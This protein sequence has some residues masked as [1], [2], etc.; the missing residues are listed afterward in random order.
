MT[1]VSLINLG[2]AKNE[3]DSEEMLGVLAREGYAIES[4]RD[5]TAISGRAI[6]RMRP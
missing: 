5:P 2:C 4:S 3:V 1:K 6:S